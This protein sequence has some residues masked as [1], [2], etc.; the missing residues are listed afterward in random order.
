MIVKCRLFNQNRIMSTFFLF[1]F[2]AFL[3]DSCQK[4]AY[5]SDQNRRIQPFLSFVA[6]R[7]ANCVKIKMN[8][9]MTR[10]RSLTVG[11]L[12]IIIFKLD[13]NQGILLLM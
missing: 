13:V 5:N 1:L 9:K 12:P 2:S 7:M 3:I 6:V 10:I 8:G 4:M 11:N